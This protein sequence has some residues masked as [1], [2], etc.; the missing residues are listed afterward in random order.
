MRRFLLST[1]LFIFGVS[2]C[3][4]VFSLFFNKLINVFL[5]FYLCSGRG[6]LVCKFLNS[7]ADNAI[8]ACER[9]D[10]SC[11][12]FV[13]VQYA[14]AFRGDGGLVLGTLVFFHYLI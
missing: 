4:A 12:I 1:T 14:C 9:K 2:V 5:P 11:P 3:A 8:L 6:T 7:C 10:M 13:V